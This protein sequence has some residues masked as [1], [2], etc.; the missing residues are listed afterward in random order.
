MLDDCTEVGTEENAEVIGFV[1]RNSTTGHI[2]C[3][4]LVNL[5]AI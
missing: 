3:V 2:R 1:S 4:N 5:V